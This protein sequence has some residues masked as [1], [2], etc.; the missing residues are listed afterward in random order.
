MRLQITGLS[1]QHMDTLE[2][3]VEG[4]TDLV[5]VNISSVDNLIAKCQQI[6]EDMAPLAEMAAE[7]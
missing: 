2:H 4:T 1:V 7:M 5:N 3:A 6:N